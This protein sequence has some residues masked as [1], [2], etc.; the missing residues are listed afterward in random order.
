MDAAQ[1]MEAEIGPLIPFW[2]ESTF[3]VEKLYSFSGFNQKK[4]P[5]LPQND[6]NTASEQLEH[7]SAVCT[8]NKNGN[9]LAGVWL[10]EVSP[11]T[12]R[13][14][15]QSSSCVVETEDGAQRKWAGSDINYVKKLQKKNKKTERTR[16]VKICCR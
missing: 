2:C 7:L 11:Q 16:R 14:K 8:W 15:T 10:V 1:H 3:T 12:E 5:F 13:I 4:I 9:R 6:K